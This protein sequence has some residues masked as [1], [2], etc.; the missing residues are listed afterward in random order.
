P[1]ATYT[2]SLHDALPIYIQDRYLYGYVIDYADLHFRGI[3]QYLCPS[4]ENG[5]C[6][7]FL[8]FNV[9][10]AAITI[11]V[12]IILARAL[13]MREKPASP[14]RKSTRLNSSHVKI[15]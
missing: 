14:D 1:T 3:P 2:P 6:R 13:F 12:L 10:D 7:P 8:V 9:A 5:V 11:G 15:S 4:Y